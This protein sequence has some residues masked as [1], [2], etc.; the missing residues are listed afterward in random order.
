MAGDNAQVT[1]IEPVIETSDA[2][3]FT[4]WPVSVRPSPECLVLSGK[5]TQA[6]SLIAPGGL[7]VR[8]TA[9]G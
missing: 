5:L 4:V 1:I 7:R 6:E 9:M 8:A 2:S 3:G